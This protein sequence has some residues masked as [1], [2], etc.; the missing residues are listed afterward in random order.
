M[1]SPNVAGY[2]VLETCAFDMGFWPRG[3]VKAAKHIS[4]RPDPTDSR[5]V[6]GP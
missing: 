1:H 2:I 4:T 3:R 6:T 5:G